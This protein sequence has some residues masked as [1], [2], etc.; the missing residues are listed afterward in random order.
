MYPSPHLT[1]E[2]EMSCF[3][4]GSS[5]GRQLLC[6]HLR[7]KL[8]KVDEFWSQH[9][10]TTEFQ[11]KYSSGT[12]ALEHFRGGCCCKAARRDLISVVSAHQSWLSPAV[13]GFIAL[14][15]AG[16]TSLLVCIVVLGVAAIP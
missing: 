11:V 12:A 16:P 15:Q 14:L 10:S 8:E 9:P 1:S 7:A 3:F 5:L 6:L 13:A 4:K 2:V